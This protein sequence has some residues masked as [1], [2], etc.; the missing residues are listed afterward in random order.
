MSGT[1]RLVVR[2]ENVSNREWRFVARD[3]TRV[4]GD[5]ETSSASRFLRWVSR[6]Y[7]S[8]RQ[9]LARTNRKWLKALDAGLGRLESQIDPMESLLKQARQ[10]DAIT[11]HHSAQIPSPL[12]ERRFRRAVRRTLRTCSR[13]ILFNM[14]LLPVTG[15]MTFV[16][17][18][19]VFFGWNAFRLISHYLARE[20]GRR[21][22]KGKCVVL[23][24]PDAALPQTA[25]Q[26]IPS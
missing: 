26:L 2:V 23:A 21:I 5:E 19:N 1:S 6:R 18:P 3:D 16:P 11:L 25:N 4:G 14:L 20:G 24:V 12:V 15:L 9:S 8:V 22:M 17:G 7:Q 10:V 13:G